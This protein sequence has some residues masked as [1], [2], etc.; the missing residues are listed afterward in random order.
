MSAKPLQ[1][2]LLRTYRS[3][4]WQHSI[5][6]LVRTGNEQEPLR[7]DQ[8][9]H[10]IYAAVKMHPTIA[11]KLHLN[12]LLGKLIYVFIVMMYYFQGITTRK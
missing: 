3:A 7:C 10:Q 9:P 6:T 1:L 4:A 2:L 11:E 12:F 8:E 5:P